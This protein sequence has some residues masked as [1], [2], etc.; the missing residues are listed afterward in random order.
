VRDS[1]L[2]R[3]AAHNAQSETVVGSSIPPLVTGLRDSH[4]PTS[5]VRLPELELEFVDLF[6]SAQQRLV[7]VWM[8]AINNR[9]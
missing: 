7:S 8:L 4:R 1:L 5:S 6:G 2:T 9:Y 3:A